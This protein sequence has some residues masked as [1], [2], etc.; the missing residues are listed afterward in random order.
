LLEFKLLVRWLDEEMLFGY[1]KGARGR[2]VEE[3]EIWN[4]MGVKRRSRRE[5]EMRWGKDVEDDDLNEEWNGQQRKRQNLY[6]S[7]S[8]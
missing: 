3:E 1:G 5:K 2:K 6:Q 4:E 8:M 7:T